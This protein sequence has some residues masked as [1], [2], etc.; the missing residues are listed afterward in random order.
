MIISG[1]T[2]LTPLL[3]NPSGEHLRSSTKADTANI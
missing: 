2:G 3:V 1:I